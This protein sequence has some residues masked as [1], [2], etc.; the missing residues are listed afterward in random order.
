MNFNIVAN[1]S[2]KKYS[3]HTKFVLIA[4]CCFYRKS[5]YCRVWI[6]RENRS[7]VPKGYV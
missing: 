3:P 4:G 5:P 6:M 1:G 7:V 2:N